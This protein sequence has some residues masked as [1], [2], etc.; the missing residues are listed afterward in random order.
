MT[1]HANAIGLRPVRSWLLFIPFP[2][3]VE[4]LR[5]QF[6]FWMFNAVLLPL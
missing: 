5:M 1:L 3:T 4:D 2:A 6:K